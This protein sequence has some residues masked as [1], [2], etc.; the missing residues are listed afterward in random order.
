MLTM[1]SDPSLSSRLIAERRERGLDHRDEVW[2]GVYFMAPAPNNEH[3]ELVFELGVVLRDMVVS[4]GLGKVLPGANVA[5][6]AA[7][8]TQD[9]RC[10]DLAVFLDTTGASNL[11]THWVGGPDLVVEVVSPFDRSR[12]KLGFYERVGAKEVLLIERRRWTV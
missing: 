2:E 8:W 1:I 12:E 7:D 4:S 10:P 3:Q 9:Y 11:G 5:G 6:Y